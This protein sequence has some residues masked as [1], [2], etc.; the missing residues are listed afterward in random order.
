MKAKRLKLWTLTAHISYE[1]LLRGIQSLPFN[2]E[3]RVGLEPIEILEEHAIIRYHEQRDFFQSFV[4]PLGETVESSYTM[5]INF[6]FSLVNVGDNVFSICMT[7]PPKD[8]KPFVELIRSAAGS[9]FALEIVKPDIMAFFNRLKDNRSL[10]RVMAKRIVSGSVNF[11]IESSFRVDIASTGNAMT[12][13]LEITGGREAPIDKIKISY[14]YNHRQVTVELSR[15]G[16]IT[17]L[18]GDDEH[19]KYLT[20]LI[21]S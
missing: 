5:Y 14:Q 6:D 8:L 11:D 9:T 19:L 20:S 7:A 3:T 1:G 21:L 12:K 10:T 18:D 4:S 15:S 2:S 17:I 13:M 16:S